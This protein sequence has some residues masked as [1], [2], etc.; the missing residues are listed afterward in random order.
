MKKL[1]IAIITVSFISCNTGNS[2]DS[3]INSSDTTASHPKQEIA[4]VLDSLHD[5][6]QKGDIKQSEKYFTEDGLYFGTDPSQMWSKKQLIEYYTKHSNDSNSVSYN[7]I[8][9][10]I[11][12]SRNGNSAIA[13]EQFFLGRISEK[14]MIRGVARL[15]YR[16]DEWKINFY[17]WSVIPRTADMN[18]INKALET[19]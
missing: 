10:H 19:P 7:I 2:T 14:L 4:A 13:I 11:L 18:K 1:L 12:L 9:R 8:S 17:S 3:E 5:G 6:F 15:I 16:N